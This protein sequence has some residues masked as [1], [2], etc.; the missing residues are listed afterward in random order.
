MPDVRVAALV[1]APPEQVWLAQLDGERIAEWF[2]GARS[3]DGITGPL[4]QPG[5]KY[6]L[7]F[8]PLMRSR[9]EVTEVE[10]PLMHTRTWNARPFGSR[11]RATVFM[12]PEEDG[13]RVD[14]DVHYQLP[15]GPIGRLL[16]SS[17]SVRKRVARDIR[18]E[19]QSFAE[20][21]ERRGLG[22]G[23][24]ERARMFRAAGAYDRYIGRYGPTLAAALIGTAGIRPGQSVLDVGCGTGAL[25]AALATLTGADRVAAVDPSEPFATACAAR[26]PGAR[27]E[28]AAAEALPFPDAS[29]DAVL[30]QLVVNFL[31]DAAAGVREMVRVTKPGGTV[32]A[33]VWDYAGEMTLL[34]RFWDA[35][36]A[37]D[38]AA[39]ELDEGRSMPFST[40][41]ELTALWTGAGL[42]D[43][44]I[45]PVMARAGYAGFDDLWEPLESGVGPSGAY[46]AT[47]PADRRAQLRDELRRALGAGD[48]PFQLTAGAWCVVGRAREG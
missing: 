48:Q 25:A 32:A 15:F 18:K 36:T 13:T 47:L 9:V 4:D 28:V 2:P 14:L 41:D 8:N 31:S 10:S 7:R 23:D 6:T 46:V 27:V 39:A 30:S 40:P 11:G 37:I 35:A 12:H 5:T 26:V 21:A 33:A 24:A 17:S 20:F 19:L 29:F 22:V 43:V 16:E 34:R 44:A 1:Q 38:P 42:R 3:V 45:V